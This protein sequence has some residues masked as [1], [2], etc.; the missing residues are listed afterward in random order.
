MRALMKTGVEWAWWKKGGP[1]G[2]YIYGRNAVLCEITDSCNVLL[3]FMS[4]GITNAPAATVQQ[5]EKTYINDHAK[6]D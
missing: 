5:H 1:G 4:V 6:C 3:Q 2:K